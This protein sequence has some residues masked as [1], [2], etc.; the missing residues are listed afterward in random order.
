MAKEWELIAEGSP[1]DFEPVS[2]IEALPHGTKLRLEVDTLAGLA[3]AADI[4]GAEW[5]VNKF[6]EEDVTVTDTYSEGS[7]KVVVEAYVNSPGVMT[8]ITIILIVIAIAGIGWAIYNLRLWAEL[9]G[10]SEDVAN[11]AK[12][13][14]IGAVGVLG[15]KLVSEVVKKR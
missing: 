15:I 12:W 11:V 14:A 1:K 10:V 7:S 3:Y 13:V 2:A 9:P 8:I 6:L 4:W 5:I